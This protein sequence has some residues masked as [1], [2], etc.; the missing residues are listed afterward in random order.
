MQIYALLPIVF[1]AAG[2]IAV[3]RERLERLKSERR[4]R[5]LRQ[6]RIALGVQ[7]G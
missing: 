2:L 1:C 6:V 7:E 3:N 4:R 5:F